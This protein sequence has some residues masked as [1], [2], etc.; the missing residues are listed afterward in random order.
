M[1]PAATVTAAGAERAALLLLT[2]MVAPPDP[3]AFKR[4]TVQVLVAAEL[5]L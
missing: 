2:A 1:L 3:A 4:M 5:R